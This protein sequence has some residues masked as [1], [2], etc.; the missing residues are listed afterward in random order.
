MQR[1]A[2]VHSLQ[3]LSLKIISNAE[4]DE[5]VLQTST[6]RRGDTL[7]QFSTHTQSLNGL[8][9]LMINGSWAARA[10]RVWCEATHFN[11]IDYTPSIQSGLSLR[12]QR[13]RGFL[14]SIYGVAGALHTCH[15]GHGKAAGHR[16][17]GMGFRV[18]RVTGVAATPCSTLSSIYT[19][20]APR[21]G[22]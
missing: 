3:A 5:R 16:A 11:A 13:G 18:P 10:S 2:L 20:N 7:N 8:S 17:L 9:I 12:H 6:R 14:L 15:A 1:Q 4:V 19:T 21:T 22:V